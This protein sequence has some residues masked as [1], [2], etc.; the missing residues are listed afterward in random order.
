MFD[1]DDAG[2]GGREPQRGVQDLGGTVGEAQAAITASAPRAPVPRAF[3]R[4][5]AFP[6][7]RYGDQ[8]GV[9]GL[10][11]G[12][13]AGCAGADAGAGGQVVQGGGRVACGEYEDV[14][15]VLA[16]Q[17]RADRDP[18]GA[19]VSAGNVLGAGGRCVGLAVEEVPVGPAG[20][21]AFCVDSGRVVRAMPEPRCMRSPARRGW[22][23]PRSTGTSRPGSHGST[24]STGT[25][26]GS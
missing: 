8:V 11:D 16:G 24:P 14:V 9:E 2:A 6:T 13:A 20:E 12:G 21:G 10:Q 15:D 19:V 18:G 3:R 7:D 5:S 22:A 26:S 1:D 25:R 17:D 23:S 4:V